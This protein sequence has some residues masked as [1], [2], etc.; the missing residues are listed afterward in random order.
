MMYDQKFLCQCYLPT[1]GMWRFASSCLLF[2]NTYIF[3]LT[4]VQLTM[5]CFSVFQM[6]VEFRLKSWL[7][8]VSWLWRYK[9]S[10]AGSLSWLS[11][12]EYVQMLYSS[13]CFIFSSPK[14]NNTSLVNLLSVFFSLVDLSLI[15]LY[16]RGLSQLNVFLPLVYTIKTPQKRARSSAP[17]LSYSAVL[18]VLL[19]IIVIVHIPKVH[20]C[21]QIVDNLCAYYRLCI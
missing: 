3:K 20:I 13:V 21:I 11:E 17:Y 10:I 6:F 12:V 1:P 5:F 8:I 4:T 9:S 19:T 16:Y 14:C 7:G 2:S 18:S 15:H